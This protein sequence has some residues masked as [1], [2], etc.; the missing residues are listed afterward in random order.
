MKK[1]LKK[2]R[3]S[4]KLNKSK[5]KYSRKQNKSKNKFLT[6]QDK[7]KRKTLRKK[8]IIKGGSGVEECINE[9]QEII[10]RD[11]ALEKAAEFGQGLLDEIEGLNGKLDE[12][13]T[14]K[15]LQE[16]LLEESEYKLGELQKEYDTLKGILQQQQKGQSTSNESN[17]VLKEISGETKDCQA[18]TEEIMQEKQALETD[19]QKAVDDIKKLEEEIESQNSIIS[20]KQSEIQ[21][22]MQERNKYRNDLQKEKDKNAEIS[23][24][25]SQTD[26]KIKS[27]NYKISEQEKLIKEKNTEIAKNKVELS[28][29]EKGEQEYINELNEFK[30]N[31]L[32]VIGGNNVLYKRFNELDIK[33]DAIQKSLDKKIQEVEGNK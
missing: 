17:E 6:K 3:Y 15:T 14:E 31:I 20:N 13:Q 4:K 27:L 24:E 18:D 29:L 8:K 26:N 2:K 16:R 23:Q 33:S 28:T 30:I 32:K 12:L 10:Q 25:L 19:L 5:R 7:I 21:A 9:Q 11:E 22:K 1:T